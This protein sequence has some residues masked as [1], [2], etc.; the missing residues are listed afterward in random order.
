M[1]LDDPAQRLHERGGIGIVCGQVQI[2]RSEPWIAQALEQ[3]WL[4]RDR[5]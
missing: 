1:R 4:S 3:V 2:G 5:G